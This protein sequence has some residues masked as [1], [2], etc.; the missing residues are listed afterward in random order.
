MS[1][2]PFAID[3]DETI[4]RIDDNITELGGEAINQLRDAVFA[5]EGELGIG[6]SGSLSTLSDRLNVSLNANG[7]LKHSA[8]TAIGLVTL[9]IVDNHIA[10]N[11]GIKEY[12]L[13]L[14]HTTS[15][16]YTIITS[17]KSLLD[18]VNAFATTINT[19]LLNHL[20]GVT[21]LVDGA[22][23]ARHVASH[24]DLNSVPSDPRDPFFS[25]QGLVDKNGNVRTATQ[26]A[27]AL[28][29]LNNDLVAHENATVEAHSASAITVDVSELK[30]IPTTATTVQEVI[31]YLDKAEQLNIGEHRAVQH[32]NG[33]PRIARSQSVTGDT[34]YGRETIV[35]ST[36]VNAYLVS[37]PSNTPVDSNTVGDDI[38]K[39]KPTNDN[40]VFDSQ[41]SQV[42]VGDIVRVNYGNG[43]STSFI[44]ESTR[45]TPGVEWIVRVNGSNL[46]N[47][48][49]GYV[50]GYAGEATARIDRPL[51]DNNTNGV[52]AL[53]A[54]NPIPANLYTDIMGSLIVGHPRGAVAFGLG[55]DGNKI[56]ASHYKLWLQLYPTGNPSD[57]V[58]NLP[59]ID[60]T[61][62]AGASPGSY[63]LDKVVASTNDAFRKLGY[64]YRFIA[65]AHQGDFGIMLA[66][67]L[68]NA[69]F[70]IIN[71]S[72][73]SGTVITSIYTQNVVSDATDGDGLDPFGF[74]RAAAQIASPVYQG[75][76]A[77][78]TAAQHPTHVISP[79]KRRFYIVNGHKLDDFA[80]T[81]LANADGYWP[82]TITARVSTGSSIEVTY[83]VDLNLCAAKLK[84]GKTIV[85]QPEISFDDADYSSN[86]YGRFII[87]E[88]VFSEPCGT[89]GAFTTITVIN[90]VHGAGAAIAFTSEPVLP[91]RLYFSEDSV[92]FN[93]LNVIDGGVTGFNYHRFH[94]IYISD[95][96]STFSHERAR[97]KSDQAEAAPP[98]SL[99]RSDFW[100]IRDVSPKLRGYQDNVASFNKYIRFYVTRYDADS[101]EFDGYIGKRNA[102]NSAI[103]NIGQIVTSRKNVSTRFY[104]ETNIDFIELEFVDTAVGPI[105][106]AILSDSNPRYIDIELFASLRQN[107][108]NM[109]LGSCEVTWSPSVGENTVQGIRDLREFGSIGS[110]NFTNSALEFL[111]AGD[112]YLHENG[113]IR[114]FRCISSGT[115]TNGELFFDGGVALVNGVIVTTNNSSIAIPNLSDGLDVEEQLTWAI[116]V[117]QFGYLV[118]IILTEDK[119]QK[120]VGPSSYYLQSVTFDELVNYRKDLTLIALI[121]V[122][123]E[124]STIDADDIE[125]ARRF[126][127]GTVSNHPFTL[128]ADRYVGNF[129]ELSALKLWLLRLNGKKN[130]VRLNGSFD[131]TSSWDLTGFSSMVVFEGDGVT[132]NVTTPQGIILG[133]NITL[134]N[135]NFVYTP[136]G[137]YTGYVNS[138]NGC[139]YALVSTN[140]L[141]NIVIENCTF[142]EE[143]STSARP[144][145][146]SCQIR[147]G[148]VLSNVTIRNNTFTDI[149]NTT[150]QAAIAIVHDLEGGGSNAAAVNNIFI[151]KNVCNAQQGIYVTSYSNNATNALTG[152]GLNTF[153]VHINDNSCGKIGVI[154]SSS[155]TTLS[156]LDISP[157]VSIKNNRCKFIGS[158]DGSN[159][160]MPSISVT[161]SYGTGN[162]LIDGNACHWIQ[163]LAQDLAGSNHYT[164]LKIINN[165]LTANDS[166][167]LSDLLITSYGAISSN[168]IAI[169]TLTIYG[170]AQTN[171]FI[172]S[173]N[174]INAGRYNSTNYKYATAGIK[175]NSSSI[176]TDNVIRGMDTS[177]VGIIA[178]FGS[179]SFGNRNN[180]IRGNQIYRG[181]TDIGLYILV[182]SASGNDT[183]LVSENFFDSSTKDGSNTNT[184]S[185]PNYWQVSRN[186]NHV[187][188]V[189]IRP[190]HG[191]I[192]LTPEASGAFDFA[193]G[194]TGITA[195]NFDSLIHVNNYLPSTYGFKFIYDGTGDSGQELRAGWTVPLDNL[196]PLGAVITSVSVIVKGT[197]TDTTRRHGKL[198]VMDS[199]GAVHTAET[200]IPST[201]TT[202]TLSET[203]DYSANRFRMT[204][205]SNTAVSLHLYADHSDGIQMEAWNFSVT[206]RY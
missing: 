54:V 203:D 106:T 89:D 44:V 48:L 59:F 158:L 64:N 197:D 58:I 14:D 186:K 183:G 157:C 34:G 56:D 193:D 191:T 52:L 74:G 91:V 117:N 202:L 22:T 12:K 145:F 33:I 195:Y 139:I 129:N 155:P 184:V 70:A 46:S 185:A 72:N 31:N 105:G 135:I 104:D 8:L 125:D 116:C 97:M 190:Y 37:P 160:T 165:S 134:R 206:Y 182:E 205:T 98:T 41:F 81:Y 146:I 137:T 109:L 199:A 20:A 99:L 200:V 152:L 133:N 19:D 130:T 192:T 1:V 148:F 39:F 164:D 32:S 5:I 162:Y 67:P 128:N 71:G 27:Q 73:S 4:I 50:D 7:T 149:G 60:V 26:V 85:V 43:L 77:D 138:S 127:G 170:A 176:V 143:L 63:T 114:G 3:S 154:N 118:S 172:V 21:L 194:G 18:A 62:N 25:W 110:E 142:S 103:T 79:A 87:K 198:T 131:I 40:F 178:S 57:A 76:F 107:P 124:S 80:P 29:Q 94:E 189:T 126:I 147:S 61:G 177:S 15:D 204:L 51:Y 92:S 93:D 187:S 156:G 35:P 38:I 168:D 45:F 132:L 188:T 108:E 179:A 167:F 2:Y 88:V 201:L 17:N 36:V 151:E 86:D 153:N 141:S 174:I 119:E 24:I 9:P 28:L 49:D 30:E 69:S 161:P 11:A 47:A 113:I 121:T 90:G 180:I 83:K 53:A 159:G 42:R 111:S 144:P 66:D 163:V 173:N 55:F 23:S 95:T 175:V 82:A 96:G 171:V 181:S 122:F 68:N 75:S 6:L 196:V 10:A 100:H 16:L 169:R 120:F 13:A 123:V 101:G 78:A 136:T 115:I 112:R 84:P 140:N 65:F 102:A 166:D 150:S